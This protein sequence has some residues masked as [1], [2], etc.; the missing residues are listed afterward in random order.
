MNLGDRG[1]ALI[2]EFEGFPFGGRPYRDMV[3]VWTIGY[4]HTKGV[5]PNTKPITIQQAS[6]MLR[7]EVDAS[8]APTVAGL[9]VGLQQNQFDA[10][11]SFV[12][13]CGTGAISTKTGVGRALRAKQWNTAADCLLQ[14][15]KAG[16][17]PVPGLTRRRNAERAL[18]LDTDD[19]DPLEGYTDNEREWIREYDRLRRKNENIERRKE[20]RELMLGQR[21]R[22]WHAAQTKDKGGDGK[23]WDHASRRERYASLLCRTH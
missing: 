15:N 8:Y 1:L 18:F 22:I 5:G 4:G 9:G 3:G 10:I 13:N 19:P 17:K 6:D 14:W 2:K 16:G 20:L 23:G 12:Y 7:K 11:V 21:K